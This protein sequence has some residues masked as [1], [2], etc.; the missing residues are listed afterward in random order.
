MS[1]TLRSPR[2]TLLTKVGWNPLRSPRASWLKPRARRR[3]RM[4]LPISRAGASLRGVRPIKGHFKRPR[5][6]GLQTM[7]LGADT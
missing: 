1:E 5:T 4:R 3:E 7:G 6:M 2:S